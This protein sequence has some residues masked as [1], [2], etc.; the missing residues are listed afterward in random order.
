MSA[1][2]T[3]IIMLTSVLAS[4]AAEQACRH[5]S[6]QCQGDHTCILREK[7]GSL[8]RIRIIFT[9]LIHCHQVC[10]STPDCPDQSDEDKVCRFDSKGQCPDFMFTCP[11]SG[12]CISQVN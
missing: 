7:V 6:W 9:S 1:S 3:L 8:A 11:G 10:D 12:Q 2:V 5:G 4:Q